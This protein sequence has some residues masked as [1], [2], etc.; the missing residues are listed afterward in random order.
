[1]S[2]IFWSQRRFLIVLQLFPSFPCYR[3]MQ[4]QSKHILNIGLGGLQAPP[5]FIEAPDWSV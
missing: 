2:Q 5:T 1:M 3:F 4:N